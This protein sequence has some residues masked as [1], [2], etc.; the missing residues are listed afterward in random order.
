MRWP[1]TNLDKAALSD[2]QEYKSELITYKL[3]G[4]RERETVYLD[5]TLHAIEF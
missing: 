5:N 2:W 3:V 4:K 1:W